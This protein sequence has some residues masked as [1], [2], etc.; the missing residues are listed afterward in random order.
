MLRLLRNVRK[1]LKHWQ[2]LPAAERD[3]YKDHVGRIRSLVA[4]LGGER[5]VGYIDGASDSQGD[6]VD[7]CT[8]ASRTRAEVIADLQ[9]ETTSLLSVLAVP[10]T[11]VA[12]DSVPRSARLGGKIASKGFRRV[13]R[14]YGR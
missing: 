5:A 1:A 7:E 3:R 13:A 6:I 8:A 11:A 12:K 14:R 10:A 4:Q 9:A 2:D